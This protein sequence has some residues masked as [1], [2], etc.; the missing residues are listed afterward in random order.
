LKEIL[1]AIRIWQDPRLARLTPDVIGDV[2][3]GSPKPV[4]S[5]FALFKSRN[6]LVRGNDY[7]QSVIALIVGASGLLLFC[8][9][10]RGMYVWFTLNMLLGTL[11]LPV[12]W[13]SQRFGW[14]FFTSVYAYA[15][16]DF[17]VTLTYMLFILAALHLLKWRL[18]GFLASLVFLAERGPILFML[19]MFSQTWADGIYFLAS[20]SAEVIVNRS[21][22]R[23]WRANVTYAKLLLFP[24]AL[25]IAI[26]SVGNLGHWLLD[27]NVSRLG[28]DHR[29]H[30][31]AK[32]S[33]HI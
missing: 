15:A 6:L 19:G 20:T 24:Y 9:T 26:G 4:Q 7:T 14:G 11:E 1:V 12:R 27:L 10:R 3:A 31:V 28:A 32:L 22:I 16:L 33:T 25:S 29:Q 30:P 23:G 21:L 13:V 8:L 18:A 17:L 5:V 2:Y